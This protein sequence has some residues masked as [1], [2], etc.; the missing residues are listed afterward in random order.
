M[1]SMTIPAMT[2]SPVFN[3]PEALPTPVNIYTPEALPPVVN[4]A[5]PE[6]TVNVPEQPAPV[7]NVEAPIINVDSADKAGTVQDVRVVDMPT[8]TTTATKKVKRDPTTNLITQVTETS[9]EE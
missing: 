5:A 9:V 8:R 4:V 2:L 3:M 7:V 1:G 6:V